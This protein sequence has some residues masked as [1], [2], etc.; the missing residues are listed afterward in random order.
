LA[1]IEVVVDEVAM[2]ELAAG[3]RV[4]CEEVVEVV[5]VGTKE[6]GK[7]ACTVVAVLRDPAD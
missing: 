5:R 1:G 6:V 3:G 4:K 7:A 2:V